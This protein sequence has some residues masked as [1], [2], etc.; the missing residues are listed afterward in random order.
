M[1]SKEQ[2]TRVFFVKLMSK[3][4][5]SAVISNFFKYLGIAVAFHVSIEQALQTESFATHPAGK[6]SAGIATVRA[7][8]R[9]FVAATAESLRIKRVCRHRVL[10]AVAAVYDLQGGVRRDSILKI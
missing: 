2:K 10:D 6:L 3:N 5:I 4:S 8:R 9:H 7:D 1:N